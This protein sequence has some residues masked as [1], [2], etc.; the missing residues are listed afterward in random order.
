HGKLSVIIPY[1][2]EKNF[3][4]IAA[5]NGLYPNAICHV[6]GTESS[7]IKRS[8]L[9]FTDIKSSVEIED[10]IIEKSRHQYTEEYINYTKHFY[11]KM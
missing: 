4:N 7:L 9:S 8:L 6:K 1:S 11:F 3:V 2:S 5:Q 10:L